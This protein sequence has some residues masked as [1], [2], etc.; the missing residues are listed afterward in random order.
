MNDEYTK[1]EPQ[2]FRNSSDTMCRQSPLTRNIYTRTRTARS[3]Q[4]PSEGT[5]LPCQWRPVTRG[6]QAIATSRRLIGSRVRAVSFYLTDTPAMF[7][8]SLISDA[9][10]GNWPLEVADRQNVYSMT[11]AVRAA[12]ELPK[13]MKRGGKA[14]RQGPHGS[15]LIAAGS[16]HTWPPPQGWQPEA[17][18]PTFTEAHNKSGSHPGQKNVMG[19]AR[20][21]TKHNTTIARGKLSVPSVALNINHEAVS[22]IPD[23]RATPHLAVV[24]WCL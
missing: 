19:P 8:P 5:V 22:L 7:S 21:P 16:L 17:R 14:E 18:H 11:L 2:P 23:T 3:V 1:Y 12:V 15:H 24:R 6:Q 9:S 13:L 4:I 20:R 10:R